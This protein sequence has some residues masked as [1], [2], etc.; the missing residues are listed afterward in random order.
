MEHYNKVLFSDFSSIMNINFI[1]I[2]GKPLKINAI[3][4][5]RNF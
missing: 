2:G 1:N 5:N 4:P 3:W